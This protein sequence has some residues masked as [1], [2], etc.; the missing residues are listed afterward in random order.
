MLKKYLTEVGKP[1]LFYDKEKKIIFIFNG[2]V[3]RYDDKTKIENFFPFPN[4]LQK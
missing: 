3:M 2:E 1:E 4:S